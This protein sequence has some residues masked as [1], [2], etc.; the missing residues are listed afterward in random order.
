MRSFSRSRYART[1]ESGALQVKLWPDFNNIQHSTFNTQHRRRVRI[2][3]PWELNVECWAL[4]VSAFL[5][6]RFSG[7]CSS[8][9]RSGGRVTPDTILEHFQKFCSHRAGR[10]AQSQDQLTLPLP[11][12]L[13]VWAGRGNQK[14]VERAWVCMSSDAPFG[15]DH[16]YLRGRGFNSPSL[17]TLVGGEGRGEEVIREFYFDHNAYIRRCP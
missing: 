3:R 6:L 10:T 11:N 8:R 14:R 12:P 13:P 17:P 15:H 4:N 2:E 5:R 1:L 9:R 7:R 16:M